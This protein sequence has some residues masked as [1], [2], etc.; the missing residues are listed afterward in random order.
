MTMFSTSRVI[1]APAATLWAI[2]TDGPRYPVWNSTVANLDGAVA[3]GGVIGLRTAGPGGRR[4][5]L[6]V[7]TFEPP[8]R[9]IWRGGMPFGLF[10]GER[11]FV[12]EEAGAA[13]TRFS[14]T[15]TFSGPLAPLITRSMPDLQP[16]FDAFAADLDRAAVGATREATS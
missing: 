15:E 14:M 10:T 2:L 12:L 7:T 1:A 5:R 16:L 8:R 13:G 9:M 11:V 6:R 4:F 3:P